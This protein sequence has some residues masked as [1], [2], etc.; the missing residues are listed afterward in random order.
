M[1]RAE[2]TG[3]DLFW[4]WTAND[5]YGTQVQTGLRSWF[6]FSVKAPKGRNYSFSLRNLN[7]H[8]KMYREG[9]RPVVKIGDGPWARIEGRYTYLCTE[10]N[11]ELTFT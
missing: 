8:L 10:H 1:L 11:M 5:A 3:D 6:H 9:M 7:N 2:R 4:I